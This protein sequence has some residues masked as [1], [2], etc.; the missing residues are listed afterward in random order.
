MKVMVRLY[1]TYSQCFP[2]YQPSQG[3]EFEIPEGATV[4]DLL[5]LLEVSEPQGAV[6]IAKGR[7]LK[8]SDEMQPGVPVNVMQV[9]GGG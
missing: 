9:I 7:V 1:G 8:T 3:V 6:V 2:G 5:T 4:K